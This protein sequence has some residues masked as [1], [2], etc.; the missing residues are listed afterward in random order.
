MATAAGALITSGAAIWTATRVSLTSWQSSHADRHFN[1]LARFL[2]AVGQIADETDWLTKD[3]P[4]FTEFQRA[5]TRI[6]IGFH[7]PILSLAEELA[8]HVAVARD[9][10]MDT[11]NDDLLEKLGVKYLNRKAGEEPGSLRL[12][13]EA[14]SAVNELHTEQRRAHQQGQRQPDPTQARALLKKEGSLY[15]FQVA[16]LTCD[17]PETLQRQEEDRQRVTKNGEAQIKIGDLSAKFVV[18]AQT[19]VASPSR[20][21]HSRRRPNR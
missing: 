9:T 10:G 12:L 19:W 7:G 1:D 4:A 11:H 5:L 18:L 20:R 21:L 16:K 17:Y 15:A 8:T 3:D 14:I 13:G 6:R 2:D